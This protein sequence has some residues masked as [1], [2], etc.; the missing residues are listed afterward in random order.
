MIETGIRIPTN[1]RAF[2]RREQIAQVPDLAYEVA[3]IRQN[4]ELERMHLLPGTGFL[5]KDQIRLFRENLSNG[6][7][8]EE[9]IKQIEQDVQGFKIEYLVQKPVFPIVLD[10]GE[11]NGEERLVGSLYGGK[12]LS[13]ATSEDER[14]GVVKQSVVEIE[15]ILLEAKPGTMVVMTSPKGESGYQ[16]KDGVLEKANKNDLASGKAKVVTY[17]DSQTYCFQVQIDG[18]IRGFTLKSDM[19]IF[20]NEELLKR[21]GIAEDQLPKV[22]NSMDRIKQVISNYAVLSPSEGKKIE[23]IA[24]IIENIKGDKT[25]FVDT[26]GKGR[27]FD[28]ARALLKN[29]E[30]LWT[31][32]TLTQSLVDRF[33]KYAKWGLDGGVDSR[34]LEVALGDVIL[35]LM[36]KVNEK[37][38]IEL[39]PETVTNIGWDKYDAGY[40]LRKLQEIPGCAGGGI[41]NSVTSRETK[42]DTLKRILCCKCPFCNEEVEAEIEGGRITCPNKRCGKSA[43]WKD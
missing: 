1:E 26:N 43:P 39:S 36:H 13:E 16:N 6:V 15:S 33:R 11:Y 30:D 23:D 42:L 31:L 18:K 27:T 7:S 10:R 17:P 22:S 3:A 38:P 5:V 25:A 19:D 28:E 8:F 9:S 20:Q 24:D 40:A 35:R 34:D 12:P 41:I 21:L 14:E 29:P 4:P 2:N 37:E 32:D